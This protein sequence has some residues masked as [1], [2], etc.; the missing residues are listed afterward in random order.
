MTSAVECY[1]TLRPSAYLCGL[2]VKWHVLNAET[3]K[4]RRELYSELRNQQDV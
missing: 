2:Y 3:A 4:G 1:Y